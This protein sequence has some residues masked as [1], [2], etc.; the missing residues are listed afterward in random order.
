MKL[1]NVVVG[2]YIK[3]KR[4]LDL[5]KK[6]DLVKVMYKEDDNYYG[7][8]S[9]NVMGNN[10]DTLWVCHD[11]FRRPRPKK[12]D[13]SIFDGLDEKWNFAAVNVSGA[14]IL[15]THPIEAM[16]GSWVRKRNLGKLNNHGLGYDTTNWQNSLIERESKEL[17]GE[18]LVMAMLKNGKDKVLVRVSSSIHTPLDGMIATF[19]KKDGDKVVTN[20]GNTWEKVIA[21]DIDGNP[22]TAKDVGL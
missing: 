3:A 19:A 18:A 2:E 21:I 4:D 11:D 12:L 17:T 7:S 10:G 16:S 9:L 8:M 14:L 1:K 20:N 13:Q 5:C 6:G 15:S 22:L